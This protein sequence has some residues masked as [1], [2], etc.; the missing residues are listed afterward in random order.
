MVAILL[1]THSRSGPKLV[2]H[3]PSEPRLPSCGNAGDAADSGN[4][5]GDIWNGNGSVA[6]LR[7]GSYGDGE[8]VRSTEASPTK[9]ANDYAADGKVLGISVDSLEKLLSPGR[10]CDRK[11]FEVC[12]DG[13]TFV[14]YPVYADPEGKWSRSHERGTDARLK[15]RPTT[16]R[17][18]SG[19]QFADQHRIDNEREPGIIITEPTSAKSIQDF[20]HVPD[21]LDSRG[22]LSLGNSE[23]SGS[24]ASAFGPEP[25]TAFH[26]VFALS[27]SSKQHEITEEVYEQLAKKLSKALAYCQKQSS[28]VGVENRRLSQIQAKSKQDGT[29]SQIPCSEMV[30]NSE[31]ASALGVIYDKVC[32]GAVAAFHLNGIE[33]SLQLHHSEREDASAFI[34]RH[35]TVLLLEDRDDVLRGLSHPE[36]S[37]LAYFIREHTPTKSLQKQAT[38][39]G[40]PVNNLIYLAQHLVRWQ[41][42]R[43]IAPLHSRNT[44][45]VGRGAPLD[46]LE[47]HISAYAKRF[48]GLPSL[49]QML[50]VLGGRPVKYGLLIPSRDHQ[51]PYMDMLAYLIRH[52]F[53]ERLETSGWL[54]APPVLLKKPM[55][56]DEP[57][58]NR[59]PISVASLLSPQLRPIEDDDTASIS[60]ERTA[61][62]VSIMDTIRRPDSATQTMSPVLSADPPTTRM[63][64]DPLNSTDVDIVCLEHIREAVED[65]DLRERLPSLYPYFDGDGA[66]EDIAAREGLKRSTVDGWLDL[67]QKDG[68]LLTFRH[69]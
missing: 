1:I 20:A 12:L 34:D 44:Y 40:I 54:Q 33:M 37:P 51:G 25:L 61:I 35:F 47:T 5:D 21:S 62:P 46:H 36:A 27:T 29:S 24:T 30:E 50:K 58:K 16:P 28:Y 19:T 23:N 9:N 7:R 6:R 52:K 67:L 65:E 63:V 11:K 13:L 43:A 4:A 10:W 3:Y 56:N 22:G 48:A 32:V 55:V 26:V 60:S 15:D 42:A 57:N 39:L 59:R 17:N 31:L 53:V 8:V 14:S 45:I 49:P 64:K 69:V 41:K 2:F 68:F 66:L 38:K 18:A